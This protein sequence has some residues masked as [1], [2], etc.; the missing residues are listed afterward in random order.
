MKRSMIAVAALLMLVPL[1][2]GAAEH[3]PADALHPYVLQISG[4]A[5]V[6][7][8]TLIVGSGGIVVAE[9][10]EAGTMLIR[11]SDPAVMRLM[12]DSRVD[13]IRAARTGET[14]SEP[15]AS[16][17]MEELTAGGASSPATAEEISVRSG[18]AP[19]QIVTTSTCGTGCWTTGT[20]Q[21]DG[22]GNIKA[23][24]SDA[25]GYD[26]VNRL[27]S[28]TLSGHGLPQTRTQ[29][30]SYDA[31]GNLLSVTTSPSA[32]GDQSF[33]V[34]SATNRFTDATFDAAGNM[35]SRGSYSF[36]YDGA[37]MTTRSNQAGAE[38]AFLYTA[39]DERIARIDI[40]E[41]T[42]MP[43]S[44][45]WTVRG[46]DQKVLR[47]WESTGGTY[48]TDTWTWKKDYVYRASHLLA[49]V[50]PTGTTHFHLDHL[51]TPRLITDGEGA[52][53]AEHTYYPFGLEAT[54]E[55]QDAERMKFTGHERDLLSGDV[56]DLDYMHARYY[57]PV[58]GRFVS[59]DPGRFDPGHPQT[60]NRY[61][62][63]ENNPVNR[64]DPDGRES[65][66]TR[67]DTEIEVLQTHGYDPSFRDPTGQLVAAVVVSLL[68]PVDEATV[69]IAAT[70]AIAG[71]AA[72]LLR[73]ARGL[74]FTADMTKTTAR[75]RS[76]HS[77]AGNKQLNEAMQ[78]DPTLRARMERKY[79][80]DVVERTSTSNGG[81]RNPRGAEWDHNS[82][83]A[84]KLDLRSKENHAKKTRQEGQAGGGWKKFHKRK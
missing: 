78:A 79:G 47:E 21:Y 18:S 63:V 36:E 83:A 67:L 26:R 50:T 69:A 25:F 4:D 9:D 5:T 75:S 62:Y 44:I 29:T 70:R 60:W 43:A 65:A 46:L 10:V 7:V 82:K 71:R 15:A 64:L 37:N 56:N 53:V 45:D 14:P 32:P 2:V 40:N 28:A 31:Y 3:P 61:A 35:L 54:E 42:G 33:S 30:F 80:D 13:S 51:G 81:R 8:R 72:Q 34:S 20:Y 41:S 49:A 84:T 66:Q 57:S 52:K 17:P 74:D 16:G 58:T 22:A 76:G 59:V 73:A 23:M 48:G 55:S 1:M 6:A 24:G 39:D 38:F 68:S 19:L 77:A 12:D 27:E 11:L